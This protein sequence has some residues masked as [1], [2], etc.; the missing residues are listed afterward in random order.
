MSKWTERWGA[1]TVATRKGALKHHSAVRCERCHRPSQVKHHEDYSK[2]LEVTYLCQKCH[3]ARHKEL[4]WGVNGRPSEYNFERIPVGWF[5]TCTGE[6][7][8]RISAMLFNLKRKR[9]AEKEMDFKAFTSESG[10]I[11]FRLK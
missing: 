8:Q 10:V 4:G 2:P 11:V 7:I 1:T 6:T 3:M 9:K 5:A